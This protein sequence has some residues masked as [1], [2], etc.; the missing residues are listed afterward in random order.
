ME[1]ITVKIIEDC[2]NDT[3]SGMYE[4]VELV[5]DGQT[6]KTIKAKSEGMNLDI[7]FP[8]TT[9]IKYFDQWLGTQEEMSVIDSSHFNLVK[10]HQHNKNIVV[11]LDTDLQDV[12]PEGHLRLYRCTWNHPVYVLLHE[13]SC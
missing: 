4:L 8:R 11:Q 10:L 3:N 9:N 6:P 7:H 5:F 13:C 12:G 2:L 1:E